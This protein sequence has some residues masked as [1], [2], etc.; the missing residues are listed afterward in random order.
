MANSCEVGDL[1]TK[2]KTETT[3]TVEIVETVEEAD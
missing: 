3:Q 2:A 1:D